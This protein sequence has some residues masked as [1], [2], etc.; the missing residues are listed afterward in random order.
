MVATLQAQL[1]GQQQ[2]HAVE[3]ATHQESHQEIMLEH[4]ATASVRLRLV[5]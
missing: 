1:E 5:L 4:A 2:A 3:L